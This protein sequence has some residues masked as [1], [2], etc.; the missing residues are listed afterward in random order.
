MNSTELEI[1]IKLKDEVTEG[2][3]KLSSNVKKGG[4]EMSNSFRMTGNSM[5]TFQKLLVG[6]AVAAGA[7]VT[8]FLYSSGKA[9]AEAQVQMARVDATLKTMGESALKNKDAILEA[10]DAAVKLGFDDED[11][12]ESITKLY[13]RTKDLSEAQK[14]SALAMDLARAKNIELSEATNLVG[15]VLSGNGRV[16]KQYGIEISDTL[17]PLE[18]LRVLQ[19]NVAGQASEFSNTFQGQMAVLEISFQN[20][21][22]QIGGVL[23]D[24]LGPFIKQF[25]D[26]LNNPETKKQFAAWTAEFKS[27]ADVIIPTVIATFQLWYDVLKK[28][29]DIMTTI[30][31]T[32]VGLIDSFKNF[33]DKVDNSKFGK[34]MAK[35]GLIGGI[36]SLFKADGGPVKSGQP[37]VV[38]ERGPEWFVPGA[39]G[40]IIPNNRIPSANAGVTININGGTYLSEDAAERVG[41]LIINRLKMSNAI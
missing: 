1:L 37:Y 8:A 33:T 29:Y 14:L 10:A 36:A 26:W 17:T 6:G 41:D 35:G 13:Q 24:A 19:K 7:A 27:W 34:A 31:E 4:D 22:E 28:I 21:K 25:T 12:A 15:Q 11:A 38:G 39:S 20:I 23:I 40:T 3:K 18:A 32:I 2:F 30:G 16:L 9:A 5:A